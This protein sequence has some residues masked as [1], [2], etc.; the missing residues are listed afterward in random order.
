MMG[1]IRSK[2]GHPGSVMF[3]WESL[4]ILFRI[5]GWLM[6]LELVWVTERTEGGTHH[7]EGLPAWYQS[8]WHLHR[9]T[10]PYIT[11]VRGACLLRL[12]MCPLRMLKRTWASRRLGLGRSLLGAGVWPHSEAVD[13]DLDVDPVRSGRDRGYTSVRIAR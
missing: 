5:V 2:A 8:E 1:F 12:L 3:R 4:A 9:G 7:H 6:D 11:L 13:L 10:A